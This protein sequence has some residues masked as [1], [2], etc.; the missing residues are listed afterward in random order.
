[1]INDLT[2]HG[3]DFNKGKLHFVCTGLPVKQTTED[4]LFERIRETC[5]EE[6]M[7]PFHT[8]SQ[9]ERLEKQCLRGE[10]E[11]LS[12]EAPCPICHRVVKILPWRP[13]YAC[14]KCSLEVNRMY[15][16]KCSRIWKEFT[17]DD[18]TQRIIDIW[19]RNY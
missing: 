4:F 19:N 17:P 2:R 13:F 10:Q 7:S 5:Y 11:F 16:A 12:D 6:Y 8:G 15:D 9:G 14:S 1:M 18:R 3:I